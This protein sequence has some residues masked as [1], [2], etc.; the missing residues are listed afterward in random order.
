M[1]KF[2]GKIYVE[3]LCPICGRM[4]GKYIPNKGTTKKEGKSIMYAW[5]GPGISIS[6]LDYLKD[7]WD[8]NKK[9]WGIVRDATGGKGAGFPIIDYLEDPNDDPELFNK[10][11]E[12][13]LRG[14]RWW[15][16]R[17]W[18]TKAELKQLIS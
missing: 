11:K 8:E 12:Q 5:R 17:G 6:Y 18:I 10:L 9:F 2:Q 13:I 4:M 3:V 16:K 15:L 1:P 7:K 14:L